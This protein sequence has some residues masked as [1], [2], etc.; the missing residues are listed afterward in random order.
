MFDKGVRDPWTLHIGDDFAWSARVGPRGAVSSRGE[1]NLSVLDR[2]VQDDTW[3]VD[4]TGNGKH[5]SQVYFQFEDP[6]NMRPLDV[7]EGALSFDI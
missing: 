7:A 6:V 1:L 4:L 5:L 3:R 2:K